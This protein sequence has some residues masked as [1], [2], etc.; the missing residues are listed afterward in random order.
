M[1]MQEYM[2]PE[3]EVIELKYQA[4]LC[5]SG[6]DDDDDDPM[7]GGSTPPPYDPSKPFG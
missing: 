3:M 7:G 4:M 5:I 6:N 1:K 2:A